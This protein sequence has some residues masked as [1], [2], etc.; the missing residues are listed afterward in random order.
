MIH[1]GRSI[2]NP[3]KKGTMDGSD[4]HEC[5]VICQAHTLA[6]IREWSTRHGRPRAAIDIY[7]YIYSCMCTSLLHISPDSDDHNGN[8]EIDRLGD[9]AHECGRDKGA[10]LSEATPARDEIRCTFE[11][12]RRHIRAH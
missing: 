3:E 10:G 9:Q 11:I 8:T 12:G 7:I 5:V 1:C 6:R 2:P 4:A